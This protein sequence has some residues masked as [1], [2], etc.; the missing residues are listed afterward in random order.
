MGSIFNL[1]FFWRHL[2]G[3]DR[4][5]GVWG[6]GDVVLSGFSGC[7]VGVVIV[8]ICDVHDILVVGGTN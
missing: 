8:E 1:L 5:S 4:V 7:V 6:A 3:L 2:V